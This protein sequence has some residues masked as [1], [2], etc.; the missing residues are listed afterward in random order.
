MEHGKC[1]AHDAHPCRSARA[2]RLTNLPA[3]PPPAWS[4]G[5]DRIAFESIAAERRTLDHDADGSNPQR[6]RRA[7][8]NTPARLVARGAWIAFVSTV[9]ETMKSK[10]PRL[11]RRA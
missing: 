4:P 7:G 1:A 5:G 6:L 3:R 2:V 8:A 9:M 10:N 11:G